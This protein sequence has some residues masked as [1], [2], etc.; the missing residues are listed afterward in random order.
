MMPSKKP[1]ANSRRLGAKKSRGRKTARTPSAKNTRSATMVRPATG[2]PP[3]QL[4]L[5]KCQFFIKE[6]DKPQ[7]KVMN[8][9]IPVALPEELC[10]DVVAGMLGLA[11]IRLAS[12]MGC[13]NASL[14]V[15]LVPH[16]PRQN[17]NQPAPTLGNANQVL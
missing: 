9:N 14:L 10:L 17:E 5:A 4:P 6:N 12:E 2:A 8:T 7:S 16:T 11:P 3:G 13:D 15:C 1:M